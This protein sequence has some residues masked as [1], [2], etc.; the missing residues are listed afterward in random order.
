MKQRP[1]MLR[2]MQRYLS[3]IAQPVRLNILLM[4]QQGEL[5]VC[6][7]YKKLGIAQNLTSHHLKI[8]VDLNLLK[9][10]KEGLKVLYTRNETVISSYQAMLSSTITEQET[11]GYKK[12]L[13]QHSNT[14]NEC[15]KV[16]TNTCIK[17]IT[18]KI[19]HT[20]MHIQEISVL[21]TGCPSCKK[22]FELTTQA[23]QE[24]GLE[25]QVEYITD[26]QKI[27]A[28]GIVRT[29]VLAVNGAP[30]MTGMTNDIEKIKS[31]LTQ[32]TKGDNT[33]EESSSACDCA[34]TC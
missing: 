11:C 9:S 21:G 8:L 16:T 28:M 34:G 10:R 32:N 25:T 24:L 20:N 23:V 5:C 17:K 22:L 6:D 33:T 29:P 18:T 3:A 1:M 14:K 12:L 30:V 26:I 31:L 13:A 27:L 2:E 4:L 15:C 7:L 19:N